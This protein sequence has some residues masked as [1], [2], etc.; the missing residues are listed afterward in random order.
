M[1]HTQS[2]QWC[3]RTSLGYRTHM[4]ELEVQMRLV[5]WGM[6]HTLVFLVEPGTVLLDRLRM[7]LFRSVLSLFRGRMAH[8][9]WRPV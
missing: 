8:T 1:A 9:R 6:G 3:W 2:D 5:R 7:S 4:R